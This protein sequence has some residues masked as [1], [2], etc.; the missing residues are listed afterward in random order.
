MSEEI[1]EVLNEEELEDTAGGK[2]HKDSKKKY[3]GPKCNVCAI[4]GDMNIRTR[5][6]SNGTWECEKGHKFEGGSKPNFNK[7]IY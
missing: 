7:Q 5:K 2:K 1:K 4:K 6:R 3:D